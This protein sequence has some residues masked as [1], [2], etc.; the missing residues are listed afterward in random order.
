VTGAKL[1]PLAWRDRPSLIEVAFPAQKVSIEAQC[2]RKANAGQTLTALGSYWKGR[3]PLVLVRACILGSLIPATDDS[4]TDLEIFELLMAM[5]DDAFVHRVKKVSPEDVQT[6]GGDLRDELVDSDGKWRSKGDERRRLLG[7]VLARMPYDKRLDKRSLRPEE[8]PESAY[9]E[10]WKRVNDHLGTNAHSHV[11]LVQQLGIARFGH[12]PRVV[13][14]FAGGGSIPFEA[15]RLGCDVYASDLN[16]IACMLT[17]GA[18]NVVGADEKTRAA[19][20]VAQRTVASAV[21]DEIAFLKTEHDDAGN[22]AKAFLY[23]LETTCPETGWSVPLSGSWVIS[24]NKRAYAKL[25]PNHREKRFDIEIVMGATDTELEA[26]V[27]G[28]VREKHMVYELEGLEH[29]VPIRTLRGDRRDDG[30]SANDLRRWEQTDIVPRPDDIFRERLYCVQWMQNVSE[31]AVVFRGVTED[32]RARE[33]KVEGLV[34]ENLKRWQAEGFLPDMPIQ[35]GDKTDEPIR[36]RGWSYWHHLF[37]PR[38]LLTNALYAQAIR[39]HVPDPIAAGTL[40]FHITSLA[41]RSARLS[42]WEVGFPGRAGVAPSADAVKPVFYNMALNTLYNYGARSFFHLARSLKI[43]DIASAP[44]SPKGQRT[45]RTAPAAELHEDADIFV[46]DPPYADAVRYEEITE[47]FI[48][49]LRK[50]PPAPFRDWIWDSRRDLSIRGSGEAFRHEMVKGYTALAEHMSDGGLQVVMFTHQDAKVWGDMA[51]IFWGAGLRVTAAWYIATE[52]TSELKKGGYVQ[53]TVILVLRKR[54]GSRKAYK[55][56]LVLEIRDEVARQLDTMVG[57]NQRVRQRGRTENLF[58][59]ADLQMAGYAA[60]LRVLTSYTQIDGVDMTLE[61]LRPR[62]DKE[63]TII[64]ELIEFAVSIANEHLVP[65]GLEKKIWE[66]LLGVERFYL[67]MLD[68]ESEGVKKL[69][70]YQNF[71]K[72]FRVSEWQPLL[73]SAKP[74][75]A[76]LKSAREFRQTEFGETDFGSSLLRAVLYAVFELETE[77]EADEV[78]SHLRDN[79][80]GYFHRRPDVI[81]VAAYLATKLERIRPDE[82]GAA[83]VLRDLVKSERLGG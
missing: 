40:A 76:R 36:T 11:E 17:W 63:R 65:E 37:T 57:L 39:R 19:L 7:R 81:A 21:E 41:D 5:N 50:N 46:T 28:T 29:R 27:K 73:G 45:I 58:E 52:T 26:A 67:R 23:C 15:A 25:V 77:V 80:Q 59:D 43:E 61:A 68:L 38:S 35:P 3:K 47:F 78:A 6:W 48:A 49:W 10:I 9:A 64:D 4:E 54:T 70:N 12:R 18:F 30:E 82:A 62:V 31:D 22:R 69:D 83:R 24:R 32:D 8:L 56:E 20:T 42:R 53:G 33:Q 1:E 14:T 75:E 74:N 79:V 66:R 2:E 72:A 55:D 13:D 16:P 34:R 44:L 51:G 60:A 71:A